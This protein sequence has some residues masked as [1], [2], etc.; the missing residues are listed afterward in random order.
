MTTAG[1]RAAEPNDKIKNSELR[2]F[3]LVIL[4]K[5]ENNYLKK[6]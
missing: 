2:R 4:Y 6:I 5:N 1:E 3:Q